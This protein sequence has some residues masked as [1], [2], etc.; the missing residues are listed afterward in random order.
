MDICFTVMKKNYCST[1]VF[2]FLDI[3]MLG[4]RLWPVRS[5]AWL[6]S[7][8]LQEEFPLPVCRQAVGLGESADVGRLHET[9]HLL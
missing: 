2:S 1:F 3:E 5:Y 6:S 7:G 8:E 9:S 4:S